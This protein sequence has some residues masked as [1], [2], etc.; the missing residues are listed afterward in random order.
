MEEIRINTKWLIFGKLDFPKR[1]TEIWQVMSVKGVFLGDIKWFGRWR[2]Y[3]FFP[4][5]E[6]IFNGVCLKDIEVFINQLMY[7][8]KLSR[9]IKK[10]TAEKLEEK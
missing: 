1:K 10:E 5:E 4:E 6:T 9:R 7:K 8:R 2:C 3:A